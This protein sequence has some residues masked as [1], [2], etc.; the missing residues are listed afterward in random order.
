MT[1]LPLPP[2][3]PPLFQDLQVEPEEAHS[4]LRPQKDERYGFG[5]ALSP[6]RGCGHVM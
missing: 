6:Y 5:F 2:D 4:I 3:P 1:P